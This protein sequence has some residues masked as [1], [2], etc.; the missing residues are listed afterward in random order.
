MKFLKYP[1]I[2][3][4]RLKKEF[5]SQLLIS[6]VALSLTMTVLLGLITPSHP[7][8]QTQS[9]QRD[10]VVE[11]IKQ[12]AERH[13]DGDSA[14]QTSTVVNA[15]KNKGLTESEILKVYEIEYARLKEEKESDFWEQVSPNAGWGV[16]ILVGLFAIF[17]DTLAGWAGGAVKAIG[18]GIYNQI[19]GRW[20]LQG[21][22]LGRYQK[23]LL[24]K[25]KELT[26]PFR[27][28][29]PLDME[30]RFIFP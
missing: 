19:G 17:K 11:E 7:Q 8:E 25:H 28:N 24:K 1:P 2:N 23:A 4:Q 5:K 29:R 15:F 16:A 10:E 21:L 20:F 3:L 18:E 12:T 26:I 22:A 6:L 13:V 30:R 9:T 27:P 14:M